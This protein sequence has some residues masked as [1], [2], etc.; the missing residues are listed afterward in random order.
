MIQDDVLRGVLVDRSRNQPARQFFHRTYP[1]VPT[2]AKQ[3]LCTRLQSLILPENMRLMLGA[4]SIIDLR[5]ILEQRRP[6]LV[7]LGKGNGVPEEQVEMLAGLSPS[8]P[9]QPAAR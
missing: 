4:D 7:F 3:A 5:S 1:D 6:L 9:A 2:V 8:Q